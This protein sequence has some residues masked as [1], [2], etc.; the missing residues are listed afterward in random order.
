MTCQ[1]Q[2][3]LVATTSLQLC[4]KLELR[5]HEIES[6]EGEALAAST[7]LKKLADITKA[8]LTSGRTDSAT[9]LL[10]H[11]LETT[12]NKRR[13]TTR[14]NYRR[15]ENLTWKILSMRKGKTT[16]ASQHIFTISGVY[17]QRLAAAYK[18]NILNEE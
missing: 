10:A 9:N 18:R 15:H 3:L 16:G 14:L 7:M 13:R 12:V 1:N 17:L 2:E 5:R 8:F 11:L 6:V 4:L